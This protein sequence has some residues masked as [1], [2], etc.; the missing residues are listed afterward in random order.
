ML[1]AQLNSCWPSD[2]LQ[3]KNVTL[4]SSDMQPYEVT[5]EV[6]FM[7]ETVKNTLEGRCQSPALI[8]PRA[9]GLQASFLRFTFM[10]DPIQPFSAGFA[11]RCSDEGLP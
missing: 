6:A 8:S 7:S 1:H 2:A 4:M 9:C 3:A 5:E 11:A 10:K